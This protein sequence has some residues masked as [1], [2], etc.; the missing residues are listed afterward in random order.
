M[1]QNESLAEQRLKS[2]IS[3]E[4]FWMIHICEAIADRRD[5]MDT[6]QG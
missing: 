1:H 4:R 2:I 6:K 3:K 5:W